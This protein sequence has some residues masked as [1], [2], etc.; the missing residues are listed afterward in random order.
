M[1][2]LLLGVWPMR[3]CSLLCRKVAQPV[4]LL[5]QRPALLQPAASLLLL[6]RLPRMHRLPQVLLLLLVD[7]SSSTTTRGPCWPAQHTRPH[8]TLPEQLPRQ[9]RTAFPQCCRCCRC[10]GWRDAAASNCCCCC[11]P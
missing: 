6:H 9:Q 3:L 7:C 8:D 1:L 4:L 11:C 2:L 5:L 10:H